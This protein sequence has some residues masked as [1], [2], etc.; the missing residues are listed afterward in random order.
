MFVDD[1]NSTLMLLQREARFPDGVYSDGRVLTQ[2][3]AG[4]H[5]HL[6]RLTDP[7]LDL[8]YIKT[9]CLVNPTYA[10]LLRILVFLRRQAWDGDVLILLDS[11]TL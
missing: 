7:T 6:A 4:N 5:V 11:N 9:V 8:D 10:Q 1:G 2:F 3:N